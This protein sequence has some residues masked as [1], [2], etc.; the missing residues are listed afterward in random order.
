MIVIGLELIRLL[1][2][3]LVHHKLRAQLVVEIAIIAFCNKVVT[4][5]PHEIDG[6]T[7]IGLAAVLLALAAS[8]FVLARSRR[9]ADSNASGVDQHTDQHTDQPGGSP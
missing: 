9:D 4:L 7:L 2:L 1:G 6:E 5:E 8:Y 3:H